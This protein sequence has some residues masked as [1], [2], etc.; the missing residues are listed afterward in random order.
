MALAGQAAVPSAANVPPQTAAPT[1]PSPQPALPPST[2]VS[3]PAQPATETPAAIYKEAMHPLDVVRSSMDNW[4]DAELS[5]VAA[6]IHKAHESCDQF[7]PA[8]LSGDDLYDLGRLCSF[9]QDWNAANSAA[10]AYIGTAAEPHRAQAYS[11][12]LYALVHINAIDLALQTAHEMLRRLPYDAEVA[13]ALRDFKLFLEQNGNPASLTIARDEHAAIVQALHAGIP[14]KPTHGDGA[15]SIGAL[16]EDGLELAF[17]ERFAGNRTAATAAQSDL[18]RALPLVT[19]LPAEDRRRIDAVNTQYGLLGTSLPDFPAKRSFFSRPARA[20]TQLPAQ[21]QISRNFGAATVLVLF[22]DWCT[23]CRK[24]MKTLTTFAAVNGDTPI[25]A[26]GLMFPDSA[27][28]TAQPHDDDFKDLQGT[29]TLLVAP[30]ATQTAGATD[31]P[32]GIVADR[33]GIVQFIGILPLDSF[34]GDGYIEKVILRMVS[35]ATAEKAS[36]GR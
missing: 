33:N 30:E 9:G 12:S 11:L 23:Q 2:T 18:E 13:Y 24:M 32:L 14:L 4:S 25:H 16:Y 17:F 10:Q 3:T 22:P 20:Q 35:T 28:S 29:A 15:I 31:Y 34:N 5:A 19:T 1:H 26:Y 21:A 27:S 7:K 6:G 8:D 36:T